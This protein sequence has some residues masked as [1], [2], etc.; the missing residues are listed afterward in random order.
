MDI[1]YKDPFS[2]SE[3]D[4]NEA[5]KLLSGKRIHIHAVDTVDGAEDSARLVMQTARRFGARP[6]ST[7][8]DAMDQD[9]F[10]Y[11]KDGASLP[12]QFWVGEGPSSIEELAE[13]RIS[14]VEE[15]DREELIARVLMAMCYFLQQ[16]QQGTPLPEL[17]KPVFGAA[18]RGSGSC[19]VSTVCMGSADHPRVRELREF[20]D[21]ILMRSTVGRRVIS[22]YY[23]VGPR[24]A[25]WLANRR[26][27]RVIVRLILVIPVAAVARVLTRHS[28]RRASARRQA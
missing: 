23:S 17:S 6:A 5:L 13:P 12:F 9:V 27:A 11:I 10:V 2:M 1:Q 4:R 24:A 16:K 8:G 18:T 3:K 21:Q 19:F 20:R 28:T 25:D 15:S 22:A 7:A 26:M 14:L